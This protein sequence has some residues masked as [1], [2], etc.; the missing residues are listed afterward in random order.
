MNDIPNPIRPLPPITPE[1]TP[2]EIAPGPKPTRPPLEPISDPMAPDAPA[3]EPLR[4]LLPSSG[5]GDAGVPPTVRTATAYPEGQPKRVCEFRP[6]DEISQYNSFRGGKKTGHD[7]RPFGVVISHMG[8]SCYVATLRSMH[9][10]LR[11]DD[12]REAAWQFIVNHQIHHFLIDRAVSTLEGAFAVAHR[13]LPSDLWRCFHS[14]CGRTHLGFSALE[15]SACCAYSLRNAEKPHRQLALTLTR[16][17]PAGYGEQS[18]DG[19]QILAH[20]TNP[21]HQ[22]GVSQLL[23]EYL[24]TNASQR[25]VGL[26]GLMLYKNHITGTGGDLHIA[27]PQTQSQSGR[28]GSNKLTLQIYLAR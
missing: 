17:Q 10:G 28:T 21:T 22:Q 11:E 6:V 26:H 23:S 18:D 3:P 7:S 1:P 5:G 2:I 4:D 24:D 13:S 15:E 9:P 14:D 12:Y 8:Y 20:P 19:T 16:K 25:A 27:L